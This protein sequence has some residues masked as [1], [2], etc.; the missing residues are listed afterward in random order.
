VQ[1]RSRER[2]GAAGHDEFWLLL[3]GS[4]AGFVLLVFQPNRERLREARAE[5]RLL[6]Q[7]I[8]SLEARAAA[9]RRWVEALGAG[10]PDAW[11]A[12]ARERLGWLAPGERVLASQVGSRSEARTEPGM[13]S[14][15]RGRRR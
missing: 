15:C 8:G 13:V 10:E 7:E 6:G 1:K 4:I 3:A 9:L 14:F 5:C 2:T 11:S 12:V